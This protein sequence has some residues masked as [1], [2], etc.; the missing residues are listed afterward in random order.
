[1]P[2]CPKHRRCRN[3]GG[4]RVFKPTGVPFSSVETEHVGV[5]E[6][7]AMRL[8]DT[9]GLD[10]SSAGG[11]MGVSR[12]TVQRLLARGRRK[13]VHALVAG[14]VIVLDSQPAASLESCTDGDPLRQKTNTTD[15]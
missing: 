3:Y 14:N 15:E 5:D 7:E 11:R 13:L 6:L 8:C 10:Q 12:G 1:M 9:E 4:R 2:R